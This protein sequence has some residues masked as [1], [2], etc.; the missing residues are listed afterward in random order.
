MNRRISR[1]HKCLDCRIIEGAFHVGPRE[2][3]CDIGVCDVNGKLFV[4]FGHKNTS[5][6][7]DDTTE[8]EERQEGERKT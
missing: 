5:F 3:G 6:R 2:P 1:V 7:G 4:S 8:R